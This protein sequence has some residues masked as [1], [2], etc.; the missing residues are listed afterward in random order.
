[1]SV[2]VARSCT[3]TSQRCA[4]CRAFTGETDGAFD[5]VGETMPFFSESHN[6]S[7]KPVTGNGEGNGNPEPSLL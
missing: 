4:E 5:L 2:G 7:S 6:R 3:P 1:M